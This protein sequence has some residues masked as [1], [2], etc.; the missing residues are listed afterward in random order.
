MKTP[1][2]CPLCLQPTILRY[3][4]EFSCYKCKDDNQ[5]Y[6]FSGQEQDNKVIYFSIIFPEGRLTVNKRALMAFRY[7]PI[8]H[9]F[10]PAVSGRI[11]TPISFKHPEELRLLLKGLLALS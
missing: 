10:R 6:L 1:S 5:N 4:S 9:I 7:L 8:L 2:I 11:E 3:F